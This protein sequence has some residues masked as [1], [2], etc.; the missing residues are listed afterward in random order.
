MVHEDTL[1]ELPHAS[2][3]GGNLRQNDG[4]DDH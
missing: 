4:I 1:C 3:L 2:S